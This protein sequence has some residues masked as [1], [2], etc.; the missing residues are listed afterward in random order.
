MNAG[1]LSVRGIMRAPPTEAAGVN[2]TT[3][4]GRRIPGFRRP[5]KDAVAR[6]RL[7]RPARWLRRRR[8][9][10]R[11]PRPDTPDDAGRPHPGKG[12]TEPEPAI[13]RHEGESGGGRRTRS[14]ARAVHSPCA[15]VRA[16]PGIRNADRGN[17]LRPR[18]RPAPGR[19]TRELPRT[20]G[21]PTENS[22][23]R[24][25]PRTAGTE[26]GPD[27]EAVPG[28]PDRRQTEAPRPQEVRAVLPE[29]RH[30]PPPL[31]PD[32]RPAVAYLLIAKRIRAC[33]SP[34]LIFP[35]TLITSSFHEA[36]TRTALATA[37]P[38]SWVRRL[39]QMSATC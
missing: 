9:P 34:C 13:S 35:V 39:G 22:P 24:P 16:E 29:G 37:Q 23:G 28:G 15:P 25:G 33:S 5:G 10:R 20:E 8:R 26:G 36:P 4:S 11:P 30:V 1:K 6:A 2:S 7:F 19:G 27:S 38:L 32:E 31:G 21:A 18:A 3:S 14:G 17:A 12:L